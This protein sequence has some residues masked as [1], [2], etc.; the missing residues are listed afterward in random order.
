MGLGLAAC[1]ALSV[2]LHAPLPLPATWTPRE[3]SA[4]LPSSPTA[5]RLRNAALPQMNRHATVSLESL[6]SGRLWTALTSAFSHERLGHL[7]AN[8]IGL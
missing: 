4:R 7:A 6:R 1:K 3:A 2:P 5:P 8:M